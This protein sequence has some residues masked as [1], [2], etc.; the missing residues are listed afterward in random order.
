MS[1][2]VF[3]TIIVGAGATWSRGRGVPAQP[4]IDPAERMRDGT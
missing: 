2:P 4:G 1:G 3:D